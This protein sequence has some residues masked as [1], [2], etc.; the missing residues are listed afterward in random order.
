MKPIPNSV[1]NNRGQRIADIRRTKGIS[2]IRLAETSDI[3]K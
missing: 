3:S 2:Q 1:W